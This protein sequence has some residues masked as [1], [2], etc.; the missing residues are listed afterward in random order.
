[1][2]M[3]ACRRPQRLTERRGHRAGGGPDQAGGAGRG[4]DGAT[5]AGGRLG[6]AGEGGPDLVLF[7]G[8]GVDLGLDVGDAGLHGAF[9]ALLLGLGGPVLLELGLDLGPLRLDR[10]GRG[11]RAGF[12]VDQ[13]DL[14]PTEAVQDVA[15]AGGDGGQHG[16]A[17][18]GRGQVTGVHHRQGGVR[19]HVEVDGVLGGLVTELGDLGPHLGDRGL[20]GPDL[21]PGDL[22]ALLG[23]PLGRFLLA[24]PGVGGL[25]GRLQLLVVGLQDVELLVELL[26]LVLDLFQVVGALGP[27]RRGGGQRDH[28]DGDGD[29]AMASWGHGTSGSG[30]VRTGVI[31]PEPRVA[32]RSC[33]DG[34][35]ER[36]ETVTEP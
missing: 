8:E 11:H 29:Q 34:T 2:S 32:R 9:D 7:G 33:R 23:L 24:D 20:G 28:R 30:S 35:P 1:M 22:E 27:D 17:A 6:G 12:G 31:R 3:P 21:G 10:L 16:L 14:Q 36:A 26:L 19:V 18:G 5:G 25:E 15:V 13:V 4:V